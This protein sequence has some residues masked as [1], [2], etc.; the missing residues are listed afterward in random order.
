MNLEERNIEEKTSEKKKSVKKEKLISFT[1]LGICLVLAIVIVIVGCK[2]FTNSH[3]GF[4]GKDSWEIEASDVYYH[5][6]DSEEWYYKVEI[7]ETYHIKG[8]EDHYLIKMDGGYGRGYIE[9]VMS[10]SKYEKYVGSGN[11]TIKCKEQR[12]TIYAALPAD[13]YMECYDKKTTICP[14]DDDNAL[15]KF[16]QESKEY[17]NE[18]VVGKEISKNEEGDYILD[19]RSKTIRNGIQIEDIEPIFPQ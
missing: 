18:N 12:I 3:D 1:I 8:E 9:E 7:T 15:D 17:V 19:G 4:F 10:K 6:S 16:M 13:K 5:L 11:D 2:K 14:W